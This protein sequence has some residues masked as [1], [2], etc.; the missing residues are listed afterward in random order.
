MTHSQVSCIRFFT[1][2]HWH[3]EQAYGWKCLLLWISPADLDLYTVKINQYAKYLWDKDD[4][5]RKLSSGHIHTGHCSAQHPKGGQVRTWSLT[6]Q[7]IKSS[8]V[9][10]SHVS[11]C[12]MLEFVYLS[13]DQFLAWHVIAC[14]AYATTMTS[15]CPS[16]TL[17]DCDHTVQQ[18]V[19]MG[20]W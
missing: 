17:L 18:K 8:R 16:V 6:G 14:H 12:V 5:V 7:L 13:A 19:E 11:I 4:F 10:G 1:V 9:L 20:T 2:C 15:I 3:N